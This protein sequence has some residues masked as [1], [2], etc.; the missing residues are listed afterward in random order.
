MNTGETVL[1]GAAVGVSVIAMAAPSAEAAA[2]L[3]LI[4]GVLGL[5]FG[6]VRSII[7]RK[8]R[9]EIVRLQHMLDIER[10]KH[11]EPREAEESPAITGDAGRKKTN[12]RDRESDAGY[13]EHDFSPSES[14]QDHQRRDSFDRFAPSDN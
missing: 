7:D 2:W 11:N 1:N 12:R 9:D 10:I 4:S 8:D 3:A 14:D 13:G 5:V 6:F